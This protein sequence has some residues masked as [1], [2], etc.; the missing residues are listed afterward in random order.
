MHVQLATA[1]MHGRLRAC[2][3]ARACACRWVQ[4]LTLACDVNSEALDD[5]KACLVVWFGLAQQVGRALV[6]LADGV[7]AGHSAR[8]HGSEADHDFVQHHVSSMCACKQVSTE[9]VC[10]SVLL[11]Q[12]A[13]AGLVCLLLLLGV[14]LPGCVPSA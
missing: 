1:C 7:P 12:L 4:A 13:A 8:V 14:C 10:F 9:A 11:W 5:P 6:P 2:S 3:A